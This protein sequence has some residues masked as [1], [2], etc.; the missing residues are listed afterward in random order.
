MRVCRLACLF[1]A[2]PL[3]F[4]CGGC[5]QR[6]RLLSLCLFRRTR[7]ERRVLCATRNW[8]LCS[9]T[10]DFRAFT[11]PAVFFDPGY[12][13]ID[14]TILRDRSRYVLVFK[15]Q[16]KNPLRFQLRLADGPALL[17]LWSHISDQF[18]ESWSEGPSASEVGGYYFI[19]YDHYRDAP[20][21]ETKHYEAV[22]SKDL[23]HWESI[24]DEIASCL[25]RENLLRQRCPAE[26]RHRF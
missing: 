1:T 20:Q 19:Y 4:G 21:H 11:P 15:D 10:R 3:L 26:D 12:D 7:E 17:G 23:K 18:T 8:I 14:A 5:R 16:T 24:N 9:F 2:Q 22:R 25:R 6:Q 13:V